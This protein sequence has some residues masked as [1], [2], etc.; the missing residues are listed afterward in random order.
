MLPRSKRAMALTF[1]P[2]GSFAGHDVQ[3]RTLQNINSADIARQCVLHYLPCRQF[4][5]GFAAY[6]H[7]GK[8]LREMWGKIRSCL[9]SSL[10]PALLSQNLQR[11]ISCEGSARPCAR[12]K[13]LRLLCSRNELALRVLQGARTSDR[14]PH[15]RPWTQTQP[16]PCAGF[17]HPARCRHSRRANGLVICAD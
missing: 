4:K 11:K 16:H 12:E 1:R 5:D 13:V 15:G 8:P 3:C 14:I 17:R 7:V 2:I 10:G 9:P 6:E